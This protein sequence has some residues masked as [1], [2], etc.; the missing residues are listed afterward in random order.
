MIRIRPIVHRAEWLEWR[1]LDLTA[2]D[3]GA[4]AGYDP[5][6]TALRVYAEKTGAATPQEETNLMRRGRWMEGAAL[7]ALEEQY[8]GWRVV[9]PNVYVRDGALR[10]GATPDA[11]AEHPDDRGRLVN[12]QIKTVGGPTFERDW[13]DGP[14]V[15]YQLQALT[16]G[17]LLDAGTN[18]IAALI[19]TTYSADL[20]LY[21]V[22]RHATAEARIRELAA[23][24]WE[25][26]GHGVRPAP[27]YSRDIEIIEA[28]KADKS[29]PPI[30][31]NFDN[32]LGELLPERSRLRVMALAA[33]AR[34]AEIDAEIKDK[35]GTHQLASYPGWRL[36]WK[37]EERKGY[38]VQP[39][40]RRVLR[41]S[42]EKST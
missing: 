30:E 32:R 18:Y 8:P 2:S 15:G 12:I 5:Y 1:K 29:A 28:V 24:F 10:L 16:E 19:L 36:S 34:L 17:L 13:Q 42:E 37:E 40:T 7:L 6:R 31:L 39:G 26:I 20:A 3:I 41:I 25:N 9:R 33:D 21:E 11:L 23:T 22:P 4:V 27:D 35:L 14:P 38:T